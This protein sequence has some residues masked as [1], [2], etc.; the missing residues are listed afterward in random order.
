MLG[1]DLND[2]EQRIECIKEIAKI[3]NELGPVEQDIYMKKVS[4]EF[5][6]SVAA[7]SRET[8]DASAQAAQKNVKR[9]K[10]DDTGTLTLVER[11]I[12]RIISLDWSYAEKVARASNIYSRASRASGYFLLCLTISGKTGCS[13]SINAPTPSMTATGL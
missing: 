10:H 7:L 1:L 5:D 6:I 9:T 13:I 3:L 8:V 12:F 2:P 4:E 11:D